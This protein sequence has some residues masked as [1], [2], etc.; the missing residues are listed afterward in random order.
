[1]SGGGCFVVVV[2]VVGVV[3]FQEATYDPKKFYIVAKRGGCV[4]SEAS[5]SATISTQQHQ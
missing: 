2:A 5:A 1:M 4:S 3:V